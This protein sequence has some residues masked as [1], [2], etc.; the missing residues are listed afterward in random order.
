MATDI[1]RSYAGLVCDHVGQH[2][3]SQRGATHVFTVR[4]PLGP[5]AGLIHGTR[6]SSR[7]RSQL[8][9]A[10]VAG[11]TVVLKLSEFAALEYSTPK[12]ISMG[13]ETARPAP[14]AAPPAGRERD[15]KD[16]L[17]LP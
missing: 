7:P 5:S 8:A 4:E 16:G 3:D 9:P 12:A 14:G 6:R 17:R 13:F 1:F 10:L 15:E 11:K 2:L